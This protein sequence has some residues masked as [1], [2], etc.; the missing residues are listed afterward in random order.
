MCNQLHIWQVVSSGN[1]SGK[2]LCLTLKTYLPRLIDILNMDNDGS[3]GTSSPFS[4]GK[5]DTNTWLTEQ[6]GSAFV[7]RVR[8]ARALQK[9]RLIHGTLGPRDLTS[10]SWTYDARARILYSTCAVHV[11]VRLHNNS[12]RSK[13]NSHA[14]IRFTRSCPVI[15]TIQCRQQHPCEC[16]T[17]RRLGGVSHPLRI[18]DAGTHPPAKEVHDKAS[19]NS[20]DLTLC[21]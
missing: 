12:P 8:G 20:L 1:T 16:M 6:I 13:L 5:G 4:S 10:N 7:Q 14:I 18:C 19:H 9:I 17:H 2:I 11:L 15:K 21:N 3:S